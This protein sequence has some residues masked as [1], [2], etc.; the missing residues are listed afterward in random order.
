MPVFSSIQTCKNLEPV[1]HGHHLGLST[2]LRCA[3]RRPIPRDSTGRSQ[4]LL[5]SCSGRVC[6]THDESRNL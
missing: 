1:A 5:L 2:A 6:G 4:L 3:E